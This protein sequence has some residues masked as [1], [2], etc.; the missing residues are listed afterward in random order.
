M[1]RQRAWTVAAPLILAVVLTLTY[2]VVLALRPSESWF[3]VPGEWTWSGRP[4]SPE[5]VRR[6]WPALLL[7]ALT[8]AGGALLDPV[9]ERMTR[10]HRAIALVLLAISVPILQVTLKYVHYRYPIEFYLYRTIGPHNGFWQAAISIENLGN[11]L[12]T[13]PAQ[14]KAAAD[15]FGHL[16]TPPPG[17]ILYLYG[18]RQLFELLPSVAHT[19]AHWLRAFNCA[20]F[21]F[22]TLE[23]PQI[24]ATTGQ[25]LV[26]LWSG[27]TLFPL[28]DWARRLGGARTGWRAAS[29]YTLVPALTLFTMR[30][31]TL[32]PLF[33]A[34]AFAALHRGLEERRPIWWF[35]SGLAVSIASYFS[36]GNAP[37]APAI[38][39]YALV[40]LWLRS[41]SG[42]L[43]A[44]LRPWRGW[45][46]LVAGGYSV[47]ALNKVITGV[48]VWE[49]LAVTSS[50]Q[51]HLRETY[52]YGLW[53]VYNIYDILV[54]AGLAVSVLFILEAIRAWR[55]VLARRRLSTERHPV[56]KRHLSL[57]TAPPFVASTAIV[58]VNL[59]GVSPGEVGRLWMYWAVAMVVSA[60]LWLRRIPPQRSSGGYRAILAMLAVQSL[61]MTLFLRVTPTGMPAFNPRDPD[62]VVQLPSEATDSGVTFGDLIELEGYKVTMP[63]DAREVGQVTLFWRALER[64]DLQYTVFVHA[65]DQGGELLAQD[66]SMP[67]DDT[68]PTSCWV[69]GELIEDTHRLALT[70]EADRLRVGLYYWPTMDRL[71]ITGDGGGDAV[72]L[73][74]LSTQREE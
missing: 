8:V 31:D 25:M 33:A 15:T 72:V 43:L 38:A 52:S 66:D 41:P 68:L 27:L 54:F 74:V 24:A 23:D 39:L 40:Y 58:L 12:R 5:T 45:L 11:Y 69:R 47:W 63:T 7:L 49:L 18:W 70:L 30:W 13:Y 16:S 60:T 9:W 37:L 56:A 21:S 65:L 64:P 48:S 62:P 20:D 71:S 17:A 42:K 29:I 50:V 73:P 32:Y 4:P 28:Y 2:L 6:W 59:A 55:K 3:G 34:T 44:L 51:A 46:A 1:K 10:W 53:L 36:F 22:V 19:V 67:M 35:L 57:R 14:M 61:A 26:P